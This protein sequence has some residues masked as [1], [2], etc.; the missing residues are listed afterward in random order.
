MLKQRVITAIVLLL[1][2][3][4][5]L[6]YS[7]PFPFL[8]VSLA[9]VSAG[10]WEWGRLTGLTHHQSLFV[11]LLVFVFCSL[12]WWLGILPTPTG[13]FWGF[14]GSIWVVL[15]AWM[16]WR[17]PENWSQVPAPVRL[18]LGGFIL[19]LA[20]LAMGQARQIGV[21][22]LLSVMA[23]VW[24]AD[25]C[26]FF[27]GRAFGG[28][29]VKRK[30]AASISPGKSWEGAMGGFIGVVCL[31]FLWM[32]LDRSLQFSSP[33]IFSYLATQ[34]FPFL[35]VSLAFLTAMSVLGDLI[36]SLIKRSADV[37]DSSNLLPG[38]G[39]VLDRIDALLPTLPA[40]MMLFSLGGK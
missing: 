36:E 9:F 8:L 33:S 3:L 12:V 38:H 21:N 2:L 27:A 40:A 32:E 17:G 15:G 13:S 20:W 14:A 35:I 37:K 24:L 7:E 30:L 19:F 4:P 10:A 5:A 23:L 18:L 26:A 39:G 6:F 28:H 22:F 31:A 29:F 34:G 1:I 25:V 11:G 16:L